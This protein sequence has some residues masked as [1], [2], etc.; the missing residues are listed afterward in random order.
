VA[1]VGGEEGGRRAGSEARGEEKVH[2][3]RWGKRSA[4][5]LGVL[6]GRGA[7]VP[8]ALGEDGGRRRGGWRPA[9]PPGRPPWSRL[10]VLVAR[11]E[12]EGQGI[13]L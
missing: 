7:R 1:W 4:L 13:R 8:P 3:E 12:R 9:A 2:M 10:L 11:R 6:L 5:D